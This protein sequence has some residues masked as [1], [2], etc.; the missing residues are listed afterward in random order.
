MKPAVQNLAVVPG[1]TYRDTLRLMQPRWVYKPITLIA[2]A[3]ARL[4]VPGHGL[5]DHWSV[6]VRGVSGMPT[7]NREPPQARPLRA[8][9]IDA[10]TLEINELSA[11][12]TNARGG[13]LAYR[14]PLDLVGSVPVM[15][16]TGGAPLVLTLGAG[17]ELTAP[18]TI[19][20][21]LTAEQT[22]AL[23]Q[24]WSYSFDVTFSDGTVTRFFE[25]GPDKGG[26]GCG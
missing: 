23:G 9:V 2:E 11:A 6:W 8:A 20:R 10:D 17:L 4:T 25:G 1:T 13:E 16:I 14:V 5:T 3:P 21:T 26:C 19:T 24:D 22:A 7:L 18:G 15:T 12:G